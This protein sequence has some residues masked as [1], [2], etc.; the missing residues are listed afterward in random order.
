MWHPCYFFLHVRTAGCQ[1]MHNLGCWD[2]RSRL[3]RPPPACLAARPDTCD[4]PPFAS[5]FLSTSF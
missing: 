5:W 4:T 1:R 2:C 3:R